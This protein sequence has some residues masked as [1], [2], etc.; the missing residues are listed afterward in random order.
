MVSTGAWPLPWPACRERAWPWQGADAPLWTDRGESWSRRLTKDRCC[1]CSGLVR[2]M[3]RTCIVGMPVFLVRR[4]SAEHLPQ[5]RVVLCLEECAQLLFQQ[6]TSGAAARVGVTGVRRPERILLRH[7]FTAPLGGSGGSS[8][9]CSRTPSTCPRRRT[10]SRADRPTPCT[11]RIRRPA[12][13][14]MPVPPGERGGMFAASA[15]HLHPVN[16][17][18]PGVV[19]VYGEP[20][21]PPSPAL[22]PSFPSF[23]GGEDVRP[24]QVR[25]LAMQHVW[26]P[27]E[28]AGRYGRWCGLAPR[29]GQCV[30]RSMA[31]PRGKHQPQQQD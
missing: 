28:D 11:R 10:P 15:H 12:R 16:P 30:G 18:W 31:A 14:P 22:G 27:Y 25:V 1:P 13:A 24:D 2:L 20:Q 6:C 19:P 21:V 9:R 3:G 29:S 8:R 26:L 23:L 7:V 5:G 4:H 17:A